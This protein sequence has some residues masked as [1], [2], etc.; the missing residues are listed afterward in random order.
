MFCYSINLK[1]KE[2]DTMKKR[3]SGI[4]LHISSLPGEYGIGDFGKGAYDFIDFLE[5]SG[6]HY[7]Q[8]LPIGI[9]GYGDS[10]YQSFSA[11]AGNP[12]FIDLNELI[13]LGYLDGKHVAKVDL[14]KHKHKI[15]YEKLYNRKMPLL[16]EAY[17]NAKIKIRPELDRF[18]LAEGDWL[19]NFAL[20]M[21][22]KSYND[23]QSW[24]NWA[25]GYEH[26]NT[27]TVLKFKKTHE[28]EIYFWIFTQYFFFKQWFALKAVA[29]SKGI[30]IIGDL[31]I[32]VAEDS[33]D[34]WAHPEYFKLDAALRP[35]CVAGCPPDAF[36][37]T[38]QLWGNPI[39][40]W[41]FMEA[42]GFKWWIERI[43][44]SLKLFDTI[45]IDHFRGFDA[46]WEIPYG[47]LTAE[48]GKWVKGPGIKLFEAIQR[49]LGAVD[50]IAEDLGF[51]TESVIE[52]RKATGFP[53]MKV[54]E[55]AFD[56]REESDYLPHNFEKECVA[57]TGTHDNDTIMGWMSNVIKSDRDFAIE[58]LKL[59]KHE[60]YNWG[61]IRGIW[62]STAYL[63]IA[64]MQD[65]LGLDAKARMNTPSTL[66]GNW[67]FRI[68]NRDLTKALSDKIKGLTK[69]YGRL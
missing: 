19:E 55:F 13:Q 4:L 14:G 34:V 41:T 53:G 58:Y 45:R 7:W 9:T 37:S 20:Y 61:F 30:Q 2:G 10:P 49:Q 33:A 59:D 16:K 52:L 39:Y 22:I 65:F 5:D 51:L 11:Y 23:N 42:N 47:D 54:L 36:S 63:A 35:T 24:T 67:R 50:I 25:K 28:S 6:Q 21:A 38:G 48:N 29:N 3:S 68:S 60:G 12:Y 17:E 27:E 1:Q 57:Y 18:L 46:Y 26:K 40:N 62:S 56:T 69:L 44:Y 66:G 8:I 43:D 31:P 15:D 64:Q 32:Y